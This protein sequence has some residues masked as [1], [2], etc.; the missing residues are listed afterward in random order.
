MQKPA[1]VEIEAL[2]GPAASEMPSVENTIRECIE[3]GDRLFREPAVHL[4]EAGGKRL[5]P[6]LVLL[7]ALCYDY[8]SRVVVPAAA[9]VEMIHMATLIHDDIMD[10]SCTR[11]GRPTVNSIWGVR[12]ALLTG[13][14]LFAKAF[15]LLSRAGPGVVRLMSRT[16]HEMCLGQAR[17][18]ESGAVPDEREYFERIER[19]TAAFMSACCALG[20]R[21]AGAPRRATAA[22]S[23]YGRLLGMAFQITDDLLDIVGDART[24]GKPVASDLRQGIITL[25][26]IRA[27]DES[28]AGC[29]LK[30]LIRGSERPQDAGNSP[31]GS[32]GWVAEAASIVRTSDSPRHSR[33]VA[34]SFARA[35]VES[36]APVPECAARA[37]L[38]RLP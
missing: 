1:V 29:R 19:K 9:A 36:L 38:A 27:L 17:E 12:T 11:R 21:L 37:A 8:D 30:E 16:V 13:D 5:R 24:L 3:S 28:P 4:M 7:S 10:D 34:E 20:S 25:P 35:A 2:L 22:L 14:Y 15:V 6:A 26:V 18:I 31:D 33:A 23:R 32:R